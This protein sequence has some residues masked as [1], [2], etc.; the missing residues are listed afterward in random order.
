MTSQLQPQPTTDEKTFS[1]YELDDAARER[2][3]ADH[4]DW[5]IGYDDWYEF[6]Y[7]DAKRI[8]EILGFDLRKI[9]FSGF[10]SQGDGACFVGRTMFPDKHPFEVMAELVSHAPHDEDLHSIAQDW[11]AAQGAVSYS[12]VGQITHTDRYCHE[13][14][15]AFEW[16]RDFDKAGPDDDGYFDSETDGTLTAPVRAF[17]RWIYRQLEAEYDHFTSDESIAEALEANEVRF[18]EEGERA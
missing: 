16:E 3:L 18:T 1:I 5:N 17:M 14:S 13:H 4:Y 7:E 8:G 2:A 15:V 11:I 12:A 6:V 9:Y 10:W